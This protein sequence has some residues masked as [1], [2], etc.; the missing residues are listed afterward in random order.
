MDDGHIKKVCHVTRRVAL[1]GSIQAPTQI[2]IQEVAGETRYWAA[3]FLRHLIPSPTHAFP[4]SS[5]STLTVQRYTTQAPAFFQLGS[6]FRPSSGIIST[7]SIYA[8]RVHAETSI[9][10]V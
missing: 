2:R 3:T 10:R 1:T 8:I 7:S 9:R 4:T 6:L 5:I